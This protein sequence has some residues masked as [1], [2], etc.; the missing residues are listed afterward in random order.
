VALRQCGAPSTFARRGKSSALLRALIA[1]SGV[2]GSFADKDSLHE[3][4]TTT[5]VLI[6]A[7]VTRAD[8]T[9]R[10][11]ISLKTHRPHA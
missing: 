3:D 9:A 5:R 11:V 4:T 2:G 8:P 10:R 7:A 1:N 6:V